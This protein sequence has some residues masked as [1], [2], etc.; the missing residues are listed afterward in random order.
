MSNYYSAEAEIRGALPEYGKWRAAY[1]DLIGE[2]GEKYESTVQVFRG[3]EAGTREDCVALF[4]RLGLKHISEKSKGE[5]GGAIETAPPMY[6]KLE[7]IDSPP[8]VAPIEESDAR[9]QK[10]PTLEQLRELR[11]AMEEAVA[12]CMRR[13]DVFLGTLE[14]GEGREILKRAILCLDFFF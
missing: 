6:S 3:Q 1:M 11:N 5:I 7:S 8:G 2:R 12:D 4:N 10:P 9:H 14:D 13:C